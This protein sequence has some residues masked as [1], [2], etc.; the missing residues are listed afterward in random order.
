[1]FRSCIF[2]FLIALL[3]GCNLTPGTGRVRVVATT[4][5][6]NL[7][8]TVGIE[9]ASG[10]SAN[11]A[12]VWNTDP[13]GLTTPMVFSSSE[14]AYKLSAK[15]VAGDHRI[16]IDSLVVGD[17]EL[18]VPVLVLTDSP[19]IN[20]LRD[21]T[22]A[23]ALSGEKLSATQAVSVAWD[24]V[25]GAKQYLLEVRQSARVVFSSVTTN[26]N[27][28]VPAQTLVNNSSFSSIVVTA[29]SNVGDPTF[30]SQRFYSSATSTGQQVLFGTQ[31]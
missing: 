13:A 17:V 24:E 4:T 27:T 19:T 30:K 20:E 3:I 23:N 1:M 25:E 14:N 18:S 8:L 6:D 26:A 21:A 31:P 12:L 15:T 5:N 28:L 10:S 7:V 16:R 2:A 29:F 22:G 9:N 11:G